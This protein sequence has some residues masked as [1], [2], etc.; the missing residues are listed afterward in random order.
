MSLVEE[1]V[2]AV[3]LSA[4]QVTRIIRTAPARYFVYEINKRSGGKRVIAH[5]SRELKAIQHF[6]LSE[7]L[8]S[9]EVHSNAM[10]YEAGRNI[11][12]NAE[13]HSRS[14]VLL[15]LDFKSFFTSI[16]TRDWETFLA[17][18][19]RSEIEKS[20]IKMY[21]Q[22]LF[23]GEIQGATI[24]SCL[25]I[26]APT[27]PKISNILMHSIDEFA[28][29][30]STK[31]DVKYTR[32]ADDI[33]LSADNIE[34]VLHVE[35]ALRAHIKK[36]KSPKLQFNDEKRGIFTKSG[37]RMVTGLI[38]TPSAKVSIGRERKRCIAALL[39]KSSQNELDLEKKG[40]LKGL[41]GFC[42]ANEPEFVSRMREKYGN[43]IVD[44]ALRFHIPSREMRRSSS[45]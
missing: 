37:R 1:I 4:R 29:E 33:T 22:L 27:S 36:T 25:S 23:W 6:I 9:F 14:R 40:E 31:Y 8:N 17:K 26:G 38:I 28:S 32:Y 39:H 7:K 30:I 35:S 42:I 2:A 3:G 24:P 16:K 18:S 34:K 13:Y 44:D 41:L 21:S 11:Y 43:K 20:D 12:D 19:D 15:K 5:P 45:D 10:A